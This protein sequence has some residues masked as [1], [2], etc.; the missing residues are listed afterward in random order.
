MN[1]QSFARPT[2]GAKDVLLAAFYYVWKTAAETQVTD[3][4]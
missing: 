3:L 4:T 1:S 2:Q